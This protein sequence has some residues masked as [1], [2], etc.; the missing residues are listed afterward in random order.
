MA[1]HAA[2]AATTSR[3]RCGSLVYSVG[4][5]HPAILANTMATLDQLS[6]GRIT[7]GLGRVA[8]R[9]EYEA[10]GIDVPDGP[11]RLRQVEEAIQC[12]RG[13]LTQEVDELRRRV[14]HA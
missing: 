9:G 3:V 12:M 5:R 1:S 4:Y 14:L 2:L 13:L 6:D 8:G 10:Y 7:F 11:V